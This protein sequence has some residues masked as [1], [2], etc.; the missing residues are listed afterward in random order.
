VAVPQGFRNFDIAKA[1]VSVWLFRKYGSSGGPPRYTG[2][3]ID[4]NAS[5][6]AALRQA[7]S[8][9]RDRI[10]EVRE[11]G[12]LTENNEASALR[13]DAVET[14]AGLVTAEMS[15]E[16]ADKQ[17]VSLKEI[18]NTHFYVVKL[19]KGRSALYAVRKTDSSWQSK[20]AAGVLN[21]VFRNQRL[22]LDETPSFRI[23]RYIDFFI[24]GTDIIISHKNH[25][26]SI[27]SYKEA[28]A[29]EFAALQAEPK[30]AALFSNLDPLVSF[31]GVNKIH[32]RRAYAVRTKGHYNDP[33]FMSKL[34]TN[35]AKYGLKLEFDSS[36][37][38]VPTPE[39][40]ADII[41][42]LLDHR[43]LSPFSDAIYDVPDATVV[44]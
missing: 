25:F 7:L 21:A 33:T 14:H 24:V 5:L 38:L 35:H 32:L 39:T 9:E 8:A 11:Y 36:G 44:Q 37:R 2:R 30:F 41:K 34:R 42:A 13:I 15:R 28:H 12:L 1:T 23:T 43:L 31:V 16:S 6:D 3:W 19:V 26:E 40:C 10:E 22:G 4:T 27:L 20:K 17:V 29:A 18:Q